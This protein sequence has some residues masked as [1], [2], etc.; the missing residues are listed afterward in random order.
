MYQFIL[1]LLLFESDPTPIPVEEDF[2]IGQIVRYHDNEIQK[3]VSGTITHYD[4][5]RD[6]YNMTDGQGHYKTKTSKE[7][8]PRSK[9]RSPKR[10]LEV[11]PDE[12]LRQN[13]KAEVEEIK[14]EF[15]FPIGYEYY[16][17]GGICKV[18]R[19][20]Y[21]WDK[22]VYLIEGANNAT[23]GEENIEYYQ[24]AKSDKV[25]EFKF[26][27]QDEVI[28]N[29]YARHPS[30]NSRTRISSRAVLWGENVYQLEIIDWDTPRISG[31]NRSWYE[32]VPEKN[33]SI[34]VPPKKQPEYVEGLQ[35]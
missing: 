17:W 30:K 9:G 19:R 14:P 27:I 7:I 2:F 22:P 4:S 1:L 15:K 8:F 35:P 13:I 16:A 20:Q 26:K 12:P 28:K 21:L 25:P 6:I 29:S 32:I 31:L 5:K 18:I 34:F 23:V 3:W 33:L 11:L 24:E 10:S